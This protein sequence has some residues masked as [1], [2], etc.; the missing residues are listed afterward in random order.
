MTVSAQGVSGRSSSGT[1]RKG[2]VTTHFGIAGA[3]STLEKERS[4]SGEAGS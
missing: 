1:G 2:A 4:R 3:L